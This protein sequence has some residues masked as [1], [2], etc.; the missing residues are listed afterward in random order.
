LTY[1]VG[2]RGLRGDRGPV[3]VSG[4]VPGTV[5]HGESSRGS[6]GK[7][8]RIRSAGVGGRAR[9]RARA[10]RLWSRTAACRCSAARRAAAA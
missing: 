9:R 7:S 1:R 2:P 6:E 5:S 10:G 4:P 8:S 3:R